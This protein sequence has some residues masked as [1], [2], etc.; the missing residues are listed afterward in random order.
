M[1]A[2][3]GMVSHRTAARSQAA[4]TRRRSGA[5]EPR[6]P[7]E[8]ILALQQ[9]AGNA[10]VTRALQRDPSDPTIKWGSRGK[11]VSDALNRIQTLLYRSLGSLPAPERY[12]DAAETQIKLYQLG[13]GLKADGEVGPSTWKKIKDEEAAWKSP[14]PSPSRSRNV[15]GGR[16]PIII[17]PTIWDP[18]G[19]DRD[20]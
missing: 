18:F 20:W 4:A 15:G 7:T 2:P 5:T 6:R 16:I 11:Q 10:A 17:P 8:A 14:S 9:A 19:R 12:N 1:H 13:R 3:R